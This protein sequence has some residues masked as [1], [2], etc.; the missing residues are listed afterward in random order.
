[1]SQEDLN[2]AA[3]MIQSRFNVL[4][5]LNPKYDVKE[6]LEENMKK[7]GVGFIISE[8]TL[9]NPLELDNNIKVVVEA[10]EGSCP[11]GEHIPVYYPMTHFFGHTDDNLLR[12]HFSLMIAQ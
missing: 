3:Q 4:L 5:A 9:N 8:A 1:M 6:A 7:F 2:A 11:P 12:F 10:F